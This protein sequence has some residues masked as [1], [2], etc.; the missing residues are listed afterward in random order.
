MLLLKIMKTGSYQVYKYNFADFS[1]DIKEAFKIAKRVRKEFQDNSIPLSVV[2]ELYLSYNPA[3]KKI[4]EF[5]D[6]AKI[7]F[8]NLNCGIASA[9]LK[10]QIEGSQIVQG[11]YNGNNHT[12]LLKDNLIFDITAD[13]YGGPKVYVGP[14]ISPW[15]LEK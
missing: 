5:F 4:D 6:K 1:M 3:E 15:S 11:K 7:L 13:Q 10:A 2:K 12:F 14:L 8:P 9:Y